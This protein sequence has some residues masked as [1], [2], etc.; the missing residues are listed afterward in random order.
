MSRKGWTTVLRPLGEPGRRSC[1]RAPTSTGELEP[2]EQRDGADLVLRVLPCTP[3]T[4]VVKR[5]RRGVV[6]PARVRTAPGATSCAVSRRS[7]VRPRWRSPRC[8]NAPLG[9][10]A[11]GEHDVRQRVVRPRLVRAASRSRA[12]PRPRRRATGGTARA[13]TP[14]CRLGRVRR[15]PLLLRDASATRSMPGASPRLKSRYCASFNAARSRGC[16]CTMA[17]EQIDRA[18]HVVVG[19][20][21]HRLQPGALAFSL[22]GTGSPRRARE[23]GSGV[24]DARRCL[25]NR[26]SAA[27]KVLTIALSSC[28]AASGW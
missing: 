26:C 24:D 18:P 19:P 16:S 12:A 20:G 10:A 15:L 23:E 2:C 25:G 3:H 21:A 1:Q 22:A 8:M 5:E 14:S 7:S 27:A 6:A 4:G 13:R 9:D 17:G 28:A 11:F